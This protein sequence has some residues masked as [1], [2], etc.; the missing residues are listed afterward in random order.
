MAW[1][2]NPEYK[3]MP[4]NPIVSAPQRKVTDASIKELLKDGTPD[5]YSHP[6]DW[7]N[8]AIEYC[9][10]EKEANDNLVAEYRMED[11]EDLVDF[12]ARNV[13]IMS[14]KDFV[15]TLRANG[16]KCF[17]L[18]SGMPGTV[19]LWV[20]VPSP[21]GAALRPIA[22]MQTPAMIEW[23]VLRLDE[24][25]LPNGED[26]RGWRT[27]LCQMIRKSVITEKRA[28]QIFGRP[29]DSI[30]SRRY[31]RTLWAHRHRKENIQIVDQMERQS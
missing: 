8:F 25:D 17:A 13:N 15:L 27:V 2:V 30:V 20:V 21:Q 31:R 1:K 11:Q 18:Y 19:G 26:Y 7:K 3:E 12:K 14:T 4:N 5:W 9:M 16:I 24:H 28:H 6:K 10:A 23:S 22:M 29:T